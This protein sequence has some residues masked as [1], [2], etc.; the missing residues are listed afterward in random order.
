MK[1]VQLGT[2]IFNVD[3]IITIEDDVEATNKCVIRMSNGDKFHMPHSKEI[4]LADLNR[5]YS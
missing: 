2:K 5:E 1:L 3:Q 4:V